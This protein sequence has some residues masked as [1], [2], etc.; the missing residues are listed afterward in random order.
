MFPWNESRIHAQSVKEGLVNQTQSFENLILRILRDLCRRLSC[1]SYHTYCL[2][3]S[4][5]HPRSHAR[6]CS[7]RKSDLLTYNSTNL[8][9]RFHLSHFTIFSKLFSF[10]ISYTETNKLLTIRTNKSIDN[11]LAWYPWRLYN[12]SWLSCGNAPGLL[13][14]KSAA[15]FSFLL[16]PLFWFWNQSLKKRHSVIL[17]NNAL[18]FKATVANMFYL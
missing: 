12:S 2:K 4:A 10:V 3:S 15:L 18:L 6:Q 8:I 11:Y 14:P 5:P 13:Y 9:K 1:R 17:L 7:C 16:A